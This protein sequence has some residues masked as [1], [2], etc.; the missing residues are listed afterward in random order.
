MRSKRYGWVTGLRRL[1]NHPQLAF[2]HL[3]FQIVRPLIAA[4]PGSFRSC[5]RARASAD[6]RAYLA[7]LDSLTRET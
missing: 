3:D 4:A 6:S 2:D 5:H 7:R 1:S